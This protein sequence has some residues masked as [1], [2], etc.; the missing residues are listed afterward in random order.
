M[1]WELRWTI[2]WWLVCLTFRVL[3][4][5]SFKDGFCCLVLDHLRP[6]DAPHRRDEA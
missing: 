5:S 6:E 2:G 4:V 1:M 3:P